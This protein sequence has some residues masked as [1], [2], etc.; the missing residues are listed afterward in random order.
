MSKENTFSL[1]LSLT[2]NEWAELVYALDSKAKL[3]EDGFYGES[4][5]DTDTEAWARTL[6]DTYDKVT[7]VL[8]KNK[9][10]F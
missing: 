6:R 2:E 8:V 1:T 3:V 10:T 5:A 9:V 7:D 4:D